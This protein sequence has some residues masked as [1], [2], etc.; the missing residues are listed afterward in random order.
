VQLRKATTHAIRLRFAMA[1]Q[2][3]RYKL[4]E[5]ELTQPLAALE[6]A[7]GESGAAILIRRKGRPIGFLMQENADKQTLPPEELSIWIAN[8]LNTK[9]AEET[10]REELTWSRP[11]RLFPSLSVAICT[12]DR[13][14]TVKRCL[15]SL[16]PLQ[17]TYGFELLVVDNSPSDQ[18]TA[19]LVK[20]L[21]TVRYALEKY[22]GLNFARN[23]AWKEAKGELIAYLDDDVVVDRGWVAGLQ[24][25]FAEHPDAA[26]FTGLVMPLKLDTR[27]QV[28]FEKRNGFRRGF[29]KK[30]FGRTLPGN[31]LYPCGAGI[32][33][34]GCNMAFCRDVLRELGGFDEAL[35]TGASLPGGGDLDIFY[36]IIRAGHALAYEPSFMVFHEHRESESALRRQYYTWGLGFMAFVEKNYRDDPDQ[37]RQF[38]HTISWWIRD[39]IWQLGQ[40]MRR[41][42]VLP[43]SMIFSEFAGGIVGLFGE[44]SRSLKRVTAIRKNFV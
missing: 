22:P 13:A 30:R 31:P 12:K 41:K 24:E 17:K 27:A 19:G 14:T 37:R 7:A 33:G 23:R 15:D 2:V 39:Q 44:Y 42:H 40:A 20:R 29:D 4:N 6:L 9:I 8:E 18:A 26:A 10:I 25:A 43:V 5:V 38:R 3:M 16:L 36:R 28:L 1:R 35:D 32:F 34:A 11:N 21:P